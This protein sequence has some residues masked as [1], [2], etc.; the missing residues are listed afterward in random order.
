MVPGEGWMQTK[1]EGNRH[2][3]T[4]PSY[5]QVS[6]VQHSPRP[7]FSFSSQM[8]TSGFGTVGLSLDVAVVGSCRGG[9]CGDCAT[10]QNGLDTNT[11]V[12]ESET[13]HRIYL[14]AFRDLVCRRAS[15]VNG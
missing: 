8:G 7:F 9:E 12:A 6:H 5:H 10:Y 15:A 4:S 1:R 11:K 14:S 2:L 13:R 3:I